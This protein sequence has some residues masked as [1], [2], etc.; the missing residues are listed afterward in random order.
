MVSRL[1][2]TSVIVPPARASTSFT[3]EMRSMVRRWSASSESLSDPNAAFTTP[4]EDKSVDSPGCAA[5]SNVGAVKSLTSATRCSVLLAPDVGG[6]SRRPHWT[7]A[8]PSSFVLTTP[9][10]DDPAS[11]ASVTIRSAA[12]PVRTVEA[13]RLKG[14]PTSAGVEREVPATS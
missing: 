7:T 4:V 1:D 12:V 13:A 3:C 6:A 14:A 5:T 9:S 2:R 10:V 8:S 11:A